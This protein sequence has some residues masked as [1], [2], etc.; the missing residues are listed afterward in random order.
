MP[1]LTTTY[2]PKFIFRNGHL[3]TIYS[4]LLRKVEGVTQKRERLTLPDNDFLD[5][6]WSYTTKKT[7]QLL[8]V[9]HGLEGNAQRHYMLGSAKMANQNNIDAVCVNF[10]GC[11]G[12][13]NNSFQSYHSG[14][15]DDLASVLKHITEQFH[16]DTIYLKGFSLGGNVILKYLGE[17][18]QIPK[19]V[20]GAVTVSVPV[21]L[22]GS[23]EK[24]M[25]IENVLYSKKFLKNLRAK[26]KGKQELFPQ[27]IKNED[28]IAIK[29]L[30]DF[31]DFYTSK[32]H[33]FIDAYDYYEKSSSLPFLAGIKIPTLLINAQNDSFLSK[34]CYPIEAAKQNEY[35]YLEMPKYGGHVGF[36]DSENIYYSEKR[37][38]EFISKL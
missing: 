15:T 10:R 7:N 19:Q 33:N 27:N 1:I 2:K 14:K 38:L 28:L 16:Y 34:E 6:D 32:A 8:I 36:C 21:F 22:R 4:G 3:S 20:K 37:M 26:L 24:L 35:L 31:D 13:V 29:T 12:E 18:N 9:L 25:S 11:S 30:K 5:L 23:L 17:N